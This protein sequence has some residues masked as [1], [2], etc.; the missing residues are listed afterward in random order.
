MLLKNI[1]EGLWKPPWCVVDH[2]EEIWQLL[3]GL[4]SKVSHIYREGNKL[5]DHFANYAFDVGEI[6]CHE[7]CLLDMQGRRIFNED[8]LQCPYLRVKVAKN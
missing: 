4:N 5:A 1:I 3:E 2:V 8:K 6:E 7:F